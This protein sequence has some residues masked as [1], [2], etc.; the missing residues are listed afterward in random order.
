MGS[1]HQFLS[2]D[3]IKNIDIWRDRVPKVD[4]EKDYAF[5][6]NRMPAGTTTFTFTTGKVKDGKLDR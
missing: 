2:K 5:M 3:P 4:I 1:F 6:K